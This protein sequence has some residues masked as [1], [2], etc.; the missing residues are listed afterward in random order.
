MSNLRKVSNKKL[1]IKILR[2]KRS[3]R[4]PEIS[5]N[6]A[7]AAP[8][9]CKSGTSLGSKLIPEVNERMR[10]YTYIPLL[11][12]CTYVTGAFILVINHFLQIN[13]IPNKKKRIS[14]RCIF[15][16]KFFCQFKLIF[17]C[18]HC[19]YIV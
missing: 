16:D 13:A 9:V 5:I 14:V 19:T 1:R 17:I 3:H 6:V 11:F 7:F 4:S 8:L 10:I 18:I 15:I 12:V 2:V